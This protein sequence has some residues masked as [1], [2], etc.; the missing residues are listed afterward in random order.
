MSKTYDELL[1]LV[2]ENK[3]TTR[4]IMKNGTDEE[5]EA[6]L[7]RQRLYKSLADSKSKDVKDR[8]RKFKNATGKRS[9]S[10]SEMSAVAD[11]VMNGRKTT[12]KR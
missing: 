6:Y 9:L 11:G 4:E 7:A 5:K 3:A 2:L 1:E 8:I 12:K 10:H